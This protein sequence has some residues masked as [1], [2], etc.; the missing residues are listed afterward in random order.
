[1]LSLE[2][3]YSNCCLLEGCSGFKLDIGKNVFS[4]RVVRH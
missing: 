1:M 3:S 4:G 2:L